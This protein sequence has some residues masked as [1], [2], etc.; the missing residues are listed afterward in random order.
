MPQK[1]NAPFPLLKDNYFVLT[2]TFGSGKSTLLNRLQ[3]RGLRES[4]NQL[5]PYWPSSDVSTETGSR[6]GIRGCLWSLCSHE[7]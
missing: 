2:G 5:D 6:K 1:A 4:W 7:C 3:T